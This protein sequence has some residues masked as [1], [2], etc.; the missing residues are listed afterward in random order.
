LDDVHGTVDNPDSCTAT[1]ST[2]SEPLT[3]PADAGAVTFNA[4]SIRGSRLSESI[5]AGMTTDTPMVITVMAIAAIPKATR[6]L[7]GW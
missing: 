1:T 5:L 4:A 7:E 6:G 2:L 3:T